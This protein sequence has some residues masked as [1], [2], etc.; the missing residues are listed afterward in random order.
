MSLLA[1][2]PT[3][4]HVITA[5]L[6]GCSAVEHL[7]HVLDLLIRSQQSPDLFSKVFFKILLNLKIHVH[8]IETVGCFVVVTEAVCCM[9]THT[10]SQKNKTLDFWS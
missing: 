2:W 7:P 3:A 6:L 8:C 1:D 10:V 9:F 4:S 5:E